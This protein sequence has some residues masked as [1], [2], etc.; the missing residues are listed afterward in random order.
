MPSS[1][2]VFLDH[3]TGSKYFIFR[4]NI[5]ISLRTRL[6]NFDKGKNIATY[7]KTYVIV[8]VAYN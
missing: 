6:S 1:L 5:R 7:L 8:N 4:P 2:P 3:V